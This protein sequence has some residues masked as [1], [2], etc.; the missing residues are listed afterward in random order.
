[1]RYHTKEHTHL[2]EPALQGQIHTAEDLAKAGVS[3]HLASGLWV[4]EKQH[5]KRNQCHI[6]APLELGV[7]T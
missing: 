2:L 6:E 3:S 1:M 4:Q 7:Q 5:G